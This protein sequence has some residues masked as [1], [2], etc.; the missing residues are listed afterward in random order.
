MNQ[1]YDALQESVYGAL[2]VQTRLRPYFDDVSLVI[3]DSGIHLDA[4]PVSAALL[5][6]AAVN[7]YDAVGDLLDLQKYSDNFFQGLGYSPMVTLEQVLR[8]APIEPV[9]ATLLSR[10]KVKLLDADS[11]NFL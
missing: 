1:A 8:S 11:S 7:R 5:A 2:V 6:K 9:I 4:T 3:D 10:E